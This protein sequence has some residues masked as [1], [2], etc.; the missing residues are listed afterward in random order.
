[1]DMTLLP[2][3]FR[4]GIQWVQMR[5]LE[6]RNMA[7]NVAVVNHTHDPRLALFEGIARTGIKGNREGDGPI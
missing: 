1:M 3:C 7:I 6:K 4:P 5:R 2:V